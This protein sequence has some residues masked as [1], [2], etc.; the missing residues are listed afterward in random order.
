M[1]AAID[2]EKVQRIFHATLDLTEREQERFLVRIGEGHPAVAEEVRALLAA[3]ARTGLLD[4]TGPFDPMASD[5]HLI[6]GTVGPY[7]IVRRL[8]RGGMGIVFLAE[9]DDDQFEQRVALKLLRGDPAGDLRERFLREREILAGLSHPNIARLYDGGVTG[10][11]IPWFAMELVEGEQI[12]TWCESERLDV[13]ARLR[14]FCLVCDAVQYAHQ[15]LVVHRDI[16]PSNVLVTRDGE[17]RLLDFGIAKLLETDGERTET[18]EQ[19]LT[20]PYAAPEQLCGGSLTTATDSYALGVLLYRLLAGVHPYRIDAS[21]PV[22]ARSICESEPTRPSV[23]VAKRNPGGAPRL[24]RRLRGDLDTIVL[25][26]LRKEPE[27]RY[28]TAGALAEDIR[29]HLAGRPV[30]ARPDTAGYRA[31]KFIRRHRVAAIAG[32]AASITVVAGAIGMGWQARRA[33]AQARIAETERDRARV[34][35]A[36]AEETKDF[37]LGLFSAADPRESM[38]R[39][40][41]VRELVDLGAEGLL[42]GDQLADQPLVRASM[43]DVVGQV[44][45]RM[46]RWDRA[47]P[48]LERALAIRREHLSADDPDL[49]TSLN[50]LAVML[51]NKGQIDAAEPLALEALEIRRRVPGGELD[52]ATSLNNVAAIPF[53]RGDYAGAEGRIRE[54]IEVRKAGGDFGPDLAVNIDALAG[55]LREQGRYAEA[56]SLFGEALAIKRAHLDPAHPDLAQSYN[57]LAGLRLRSGDAAGAERSY[58][59]A[60]AIYRRIDPNHSVVATIVSNLGS[61]LETQGRYTEAESAYLES[62]RIRRA[63]FGDEN[64]DVSV[65]LNNLGLLYAR[66]GRFAEARPM[67]EESLAVRLGVHGESH[68]M[69]G[70][71]YHNLGFL[72]EEEGNVERAAELYRRAWEIRLATLGETHPETEES[73]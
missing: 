9:R 68:P 63:L 52:V 51:L 7:R 48:I 37:M 28:A 35:A 2:W 22:L 54:A 71:A 14:L 43:L 44:Y 47:R 49:A 21:F 6:G 69:V 38:G 66:T 72:T 3:H 65:S 27:R 30:A 18:V 19:R 33:T 20:P 42:E 24:E 11:G 73:A 59:E 15:N 70:R 23:A 32:L 53:M 40:I 1:T 26:A 61:S 13:E 56:D 57:N 4:G 8:G 31:S 58:R 25:K 12:E 36:R 39:E 62:L 29:R 55:I 50:S 46:N 10:S 5:A 16:K 64:D 60:L 45:D 34:E 41:T 67:L 17:P